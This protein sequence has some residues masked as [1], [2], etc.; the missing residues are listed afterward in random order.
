MSADALIPLLVLIGLLISLYG[1]I[2]GFGGGIFMVPILVSV[3]GYGLDVAAGT[4]MISL[5][6]SSIISTYLNRKKGQVDFKMGILLEVPTIAGVVLGSLIL[7]YFSATG[8]LLYLEVFFALMI[9]VLGST[10]FIGKDTDKPKKEGFFYKLNKQK[11]ALVIKNHLNFVAYRI[12]LVMAL[13]FGLVSGALAGLFGVG[14]G[15]MKTPIMLKV[16]KIPVKIAA[17]TALFMIV[18]TSIS[19]SIMHGLQ[20]HILIAKAWPVALGFT[21]G[22]IIGYKVNTHLNEA[23]L[24]KLIGVSLVSAG[25]MM[26]LKFVVIG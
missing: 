11:P 12:S 25:L 17:A 1:S 14:G 24:E 23:F 9:L 2:V 26:I 22:A 10:F 7:T 21:L 19:G 18:I 16:F 5:V 3:F 4:A 13:F 6:P 8:K 15:F 20:G